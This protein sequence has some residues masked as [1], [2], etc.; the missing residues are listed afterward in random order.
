[1]DSNI[2][3]V[4]QVSKNKAIL[5]FKNMKYDAYIG[6]NGTSESKREGDKKTPLGEYALGLC[7]GIHE[8]KYLNLDE[9]LEYKKLT[10]TMY[11]VSDS[12]SKYY[13]RFVDTKEIE[14]DWNAD[15][16]LIDYAIEYEYA[17]EVKYNKACIPN[18][19][20]AIFIHCENSKPTAGCISL[21]RTA[22]KNILENIN[23]KTKIV[24]KS[25][26]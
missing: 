22:M 16:H 10:N 21:K 7:F 2:I 20:S 1:M 6:E 13:N 15:E 9:S 26:I 17:I 8:K 18:K 3:Y 11:W 24:I 25:M 5:E 4:T 19:G 14:K 23:S 12:N